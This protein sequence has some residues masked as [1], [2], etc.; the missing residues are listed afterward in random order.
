MV[1][2]VYELAWDCIH[3]VVLAAALK[4]ERGDRGKLRGDEVQFWDL[5]NLALLWCLLSI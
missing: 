4:R 2:V 1:E 5:E 3:E